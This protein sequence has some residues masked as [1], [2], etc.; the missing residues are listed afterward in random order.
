MHDELERIWKEVVVAYFKAL[1]WHISTET[2]EN[3]KNPYLG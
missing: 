3:H 2:E 1:P